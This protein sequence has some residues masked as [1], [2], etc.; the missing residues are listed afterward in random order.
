MKTLCTIF[1]NKINRVVPLI[2]INCLN[3]G[4][5]IQF[6]SINGIFH[7]RLNG[8]SLQIK[9]QLK[10]ST[11]FIEVKLTNISSYDLIFFMD[12]IT[13]RHCFNIRIC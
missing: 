8:K 9:C 12:L 10:Y 1:E 6:Y 7:K 4:F 13:K 11:L 5:E 2:L 3:E